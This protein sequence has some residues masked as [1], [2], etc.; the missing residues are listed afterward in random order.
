SV[1]PA[2]AA[3]RASKKTILSPLPGSIPGPTDNPVTAE[4]AELGKQLFFDPRLSGANTTSCATCHIPEK[5][6]TDGL[7][8]AAGL[9]GKPLSRNTPTLLNV[10]FY[11]SYFW[12][13]RA[14]SLEE[15]AL[16]PIES[17][18]EMNQ[19]LDELEVEL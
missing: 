3:E 11:E 16:A 9:Q 18:D 19:N 10:G 15:Q 17:P 5:A 6:F 4:K 8:R 14:N 12:D 1:G 2:S 7:P 13:G